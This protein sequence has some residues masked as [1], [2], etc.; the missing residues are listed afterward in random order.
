MPHAFFKAN[1]YSCLLGRCL[2]HPSTTHTEKKK[3]NKKIIMQ[4]H[5]NHYTR[6]KGRFA[7]WKSK[8]LLDS[9]FANCFADAYSSNAGMAPPRQQHK[10]LRRS[11]IS[12]LVGKGFW[13][14]FPNRKSL[15]CIRGDRTSSSVVQ[16]SFPSPFIP[17]LPLPLCWAGWDWAQ[18]EKKRL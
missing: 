8:D 17:A 5:K 4:H 2:W 7:F 10:R 16:P 12:F 13:L 11:K 1:I 3:N 6:K 14:L 15:W 9:S 18:A